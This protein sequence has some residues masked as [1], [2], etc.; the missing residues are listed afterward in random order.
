MYLLNIYNWMSPLATEPLNHDWPKLLI[1]LFNN[2][3]RAVKYESV[4]VLNGSNR[5]RTHP[6]KLLPLPYSFIYYLYGKVPSI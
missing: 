2:A 5:I 4:G 1:Y 3:S 6:T